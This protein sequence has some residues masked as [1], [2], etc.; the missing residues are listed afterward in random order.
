VKLQIHQLSNVPL[1]G[2]Q[3]GVKWRFKHVQ[4][5][6][7]NAGLLA[8]MRAN[9][10]SPHIDVGKGKGRE[11]NVDEDATTGDEDYQ[12]VDGTHGHGIYINDF[13][14]PSGSSYFTA[15]GSKL[16]SSSSTT[17]SSDSSSFYTTPSHTPASSIS[18][19]HSY[20]DGRGVT[21]WAPLLEH[22]A[23]WE[24]TV[25]VVVR[26]DVDRETSILQSNDL[27]LTIMQV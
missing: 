11:L 17:A 27:K 13:Q 12:A 3:F 1:L 8:K 9:K 6:G 23:K 10:S 14:V 4:S 21:D 19:E 24:H 22:T 26:M 2:G 5:A 20:S 15:G 25:S 18:T 16:S 7:R